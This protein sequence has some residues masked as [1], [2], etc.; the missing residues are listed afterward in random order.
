MTRVTLKTLLLL[1]KSLCDLATDC[2]P[3]ICLRGNMFTN[4]LPSSGCTCNNIMKANNNIIWNNF[5]ASYSVRSRLVCPSYY[6][7]FVYLLSV[8]LQVIVRIWH[9][10]QSPFKKNPSPFKLSFSFHSTACNVRSWSS[11]M[12]LLK[13][14]SVVRVIVNVSLDMIFSFVPKKSGNSTYFHDE[15][16]HELFKCILS[17]FAYIV[18]LQ[19]HLL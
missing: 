13:K 4:P 10:S 14:Q 11:V 8:S 16:L 1:S 18:Y 12:N 2:L 7:L 9:W 15:D 5:R 17:H 19:N 6:W 3:R